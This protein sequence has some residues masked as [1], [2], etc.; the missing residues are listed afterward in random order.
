MK[1]LWNIKYFPSPEFLVIT[2][3]FNKLCSFRMKMPAC[4]CINKHMGYDPTVN[5]LEMMSEMGIG[6]MVKKPRFHIKALISILWIQKFPNYAK[7]WRGKWWHVCLGSYQPWGRPGLSALSPAM[8][9]SATTM[10]IW[11]VNQWV[12]SFNLS[13]SFS[14]T[15]PT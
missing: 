15:T 6:V 1:T 11:K 13:L 7:P 4:S 5:V 14:L 8:V 10:S 2:T 9:L 3:Q 12:P